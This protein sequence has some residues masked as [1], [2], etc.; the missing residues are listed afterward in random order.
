MELRHL[1]TFIAVVEAGSFTRAANQLNY[2]QSSVT[3]QI[4]ALETELGSALFDRL[5]SKTVLTEAGKRFLPY[6]QDLTRMHDRAKDAIRLQSDFTGTL[7][8]GAPESMA[9]FR[10]PNV[11]REYKK[12]YPAVNIILKPGLCWEMGDR[13]RSGELDMALFMDPE[14]ED[15]DLNKITL[16]QEHMAL[17]AAPDHPLTV[18]TLVE[19]QD[20]KEE[21][22]LCTEPGC[23]YRALFERVLN[24][25][26]IHPNPSLEFWSIEAI[27]NCVMSGLGVAL[28]PLVTVRSELEEGKLVRLAWDDRPQRLCTQIATHKN[29]VW[30]PSLQEFIRLME[31]HA[32][33]WREEFRLEGFRQEEQ[34][35]G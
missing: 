8:I 13:L 31:Q 23:T 5:G 7:T 12:K 15:R 34:D 25:H 3:A 11:I 33:L 27:K 32:E 9:A 10:L 20:L 22:I 30:T 21:T 1:F 16:V 29:K 24:A 2:A 28:L 26:G 4:Q 35:A 14:S 17:I 6:A 19:P 18:R